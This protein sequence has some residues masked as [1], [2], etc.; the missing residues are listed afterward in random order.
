MVSAGIRAPTGCALATAPGESRHSTSCHR[1]GL[2]R[3]AHLRG[4]LRPGWQECV[5]TQHGQRPIRQDPHKPTVRELLHDFGLDIEAEAAT[6]NGELLEGELVVARH[7]P[8]ERDAVTAAIGP[9]QH[10]G[11]VMPD[12]KRDEVMSGQVVGC[13]RGAARLQICWRRD[14]DVGPVRQV[15]T[16]QAGRRWGRANRNRNIDALAHEILEIVGGEE[17]QGKR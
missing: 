15:P 12:R 6:G 1:Q 9:S 10:I 11:A 16:H 5:D 4:L 13:A 2:E 14:D 17:A 3:R 8:V 7:A